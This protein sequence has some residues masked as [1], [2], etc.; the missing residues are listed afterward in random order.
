MA[1]FLLLLG[2][3]TLKDS[4]RVL[5]LDEQ[6]E[7]IP[8]MEAALTAVGYQVVGKITTADNIQAVVGRSRPDVI[9]ADLDSPGRDT[10]E[11]MQ[12]L[13]SKQPRPIMM[14]TNDSDL[15]TI[16]LAVQSGVTAYV[17]DGMAPDRIKP[18]LEVAMLC[19][20]QYQ[21]HRDEL[22]L[23]RLQLTE[24]RHIEKAKALLRKRK[25]LDEVQAYAVLR[26]MATDRHMKLAELCRS[27]VAA[28]E[29]LE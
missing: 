7:R 8:A 25:G 29:L 9:I 19:F 16:R 15:A 21:K 10:L 23:T 2:M 20:Q 26:R 28:A 5:L 14:F 13:N 18:M 24:R 12:V 11:S 1:R 22:E 17:V 6:T 4:L 3:T 27:I